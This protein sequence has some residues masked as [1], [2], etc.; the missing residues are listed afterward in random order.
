M[1]W[2]GGHIVGLTLTIGIHTESSNIFGCGARTA[3]ATTGHRQLQASNLGAAAHKLYGHAKQPGEHLRVFATFVR[4]CIEVNAT[5][6]LSRYLEVAQKAS[7]S[8]HDRH[9][10]FNAKLAERRGQ[11][12]ANGE[13]TMGHENNQSAI[14]N[15]LFCELPA[16]YCS[17]Q[18][19]RDV[20]VRRIRPSHAVCGRQLCCPC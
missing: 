3:P 6:K 16:Y 8:G 9:S 15:G 1:G 2:P 12:P 7:S 4:V 19:R 20:P 13:P 11:M 17:N 5:I 14:R 10:R 18:V